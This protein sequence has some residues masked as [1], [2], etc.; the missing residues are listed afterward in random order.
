MTKSYIVK[1]RI[2]EATDKKLKNLIKQSGRSVSILMREL[3][4]NAKL[5]ETVALRPTATIDL[6]NIDSD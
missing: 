2:D 5:V 4:R 3:I 6:S 1:A